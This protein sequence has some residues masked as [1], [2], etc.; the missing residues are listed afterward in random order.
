MYEHAWN[1]GAEQ[2]EHL[3]AIPS[4]F[5]LT[6]WSCHDNIPSGNYVGWVCHYVYRCVSLSMPIVSPSPGRLPLLQPL[7][8]I[9]GEPSIDVGVF[10]LE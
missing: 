1:V 4:L 6:V 8:P 9:R 7:A 3:S 2:G 10:S 5:V